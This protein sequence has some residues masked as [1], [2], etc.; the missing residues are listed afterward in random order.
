MA[1]NLV[2]IIQELVSGMQSSHLE[3]D[4]KEDSMY[5]L[6]GMNINIM[7]HLTHIQSHVHIMTNVLML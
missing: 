4:L 1:M 2:I 3:S 6:H 5:T 7:E